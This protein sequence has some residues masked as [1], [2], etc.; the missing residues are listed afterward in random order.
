MALVSDS[1]IPVAAQ[2][3]SCLQSVR[4][5]EGA[6]LGLDTLVGLA[7]HNGQYGNLSLGKWLIAHDRIVI[8]DFVEP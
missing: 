2:T 5:G 6:S 8:R 3:S 4:D 1:V 7:G